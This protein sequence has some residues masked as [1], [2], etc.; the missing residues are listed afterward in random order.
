MLLRCRLSND[1]LDEFMNKYENIG[2][3]FRAESPVVTAKVTRSIS[4][5][6]ITE[7]QTWQSIVID[8][9]LHIS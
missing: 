4:G 3:N 2:Q 7:D 6:T 1:W 9:I 5:F 8:E